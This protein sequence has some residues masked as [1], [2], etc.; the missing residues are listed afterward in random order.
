MRIVGLTGSIGMGK[1]TTAGFFRAAGVPVHNADEA[2]HHL[3][4]GAAVP[5]IEAAFPGTTRDGVVDR[6]ALGRNVLGDGQKLKQLEALI[7]PLVSADRDAFLERA[8]SKGAL[9]AVLDVP[10]LFETGGAEHVDVIVV[11]TAPAPVQRA[12]VLERPGM[13]VEKFEAILAKQMPDAEKR[14]R[15]H[16]VIDTGRGM[17]AAQRDVDSVVRMF[18]GR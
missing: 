5:L 15:A 11:A 8:R 12:R 14:R 4:A 3:Y 6:A 17:E 7:H 16:V 18:A 10:L 13:S 9:L 2:V 1:S